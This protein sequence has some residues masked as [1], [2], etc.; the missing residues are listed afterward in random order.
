ML[1]TTHVSSGAVLGRLVRRPGPAVSVGIASHFALDA[2]PH[3]GS[4][5]SDSR[6][7]MDDT[8]LRV[9]VVDGLIGLILIALL[10]RAASP[11]ERLAVLAG[12][13]GACLPDLDKPGRL[14]FG[15]SPFPGVVDRVH[16]AVQREHPRLLARDAVVALVAGAAMVRALS[17]A[18]R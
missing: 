13:T 18:P 12:I 3:W 9:A 1:I 2:L 6:H 10:A 17:R 7:G 8:M 14:F 16:A 11:R 15:R 5:W 4:G